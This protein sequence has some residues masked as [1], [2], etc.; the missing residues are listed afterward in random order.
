MK[1]TDENEEEERKK[2]KN[3]KVPFIL[4]TIRGLVKKK[5]NKI[6]SVNSSKKIWLFLFFSLKLN[7]KYNYFKWKQKIVLNF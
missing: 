7:Y 5:T 1:V 3:K 4:S 2:N 6:N